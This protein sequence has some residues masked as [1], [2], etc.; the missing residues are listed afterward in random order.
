MDPEAIAQRLIVLLRERSDV[1]ANGGTP[2]TQD[3]GLL[4][5]GIGLDSVEV[6]ALIGAIEEDFD[7]TIDDADLLPEHF[8][9][10]GT[11]VRFI[12]DRLP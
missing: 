12:G 10:V 2:I 9:T 11:L 1:L 3:T 7:I 6:L 4:G 5:Q 8:Q